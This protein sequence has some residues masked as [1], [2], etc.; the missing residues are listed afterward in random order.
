MSMV[1]V[2]SLLI[3]ARTCSKELDK[4]RK[5]NSDL[6]RGRKIDIYNDLRIRKFQ[7]VNYHVNEYVQHYDI[8]PYDTMEKLAV[9]LTRDLQ[10]SMTYAMRE[11][12]Y[13]AI[14]DKVVTD[15]RTKEDNASVKEIKIVFPMI[16]FK[17]ENID[18]ELVEYPKKAGSK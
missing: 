17:S 12:I 5:E 16:D 14:F 8:G 7:I 11:S 18:V 10:E 3:V 6:K 2:V 1:Y 13:T 4:L 15:D 9:K